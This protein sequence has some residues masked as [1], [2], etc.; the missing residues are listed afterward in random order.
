[1]TYNVA[2]NGMAGFLRN[3]L[4]LTRKTSNSIVGGEIGSNIVDGG[5]YLTTGKNWNQTAQEF[6]A[7]PIIADYIN[8]GDIIGAGLGTK[9]L[10]P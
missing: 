2:R 10:L 4:P 3:P 5:L 9:Y 1:M 7:P 6:G 8:P